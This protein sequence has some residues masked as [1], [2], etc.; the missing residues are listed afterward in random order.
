MLYQTCCRGVENEM[1][2]VSDLGDTQRCCARFLSSDVAQK[3]QAEIPAKKLQRA[4][5]IE[6]LISHIKNLLSEEG[7]A[8]C[9]PRVLQTVVRELHLAMGGEIHNLSCLP[10][11]IAQIAFK[12]GQDETMSETAVNGAK[13]EALAPAVEEKR[14]KLVVASMFFGQRY[15]Q[16]LA[17]VRDN[18]ERYCR[19]HDYLYALADWKLDGKDARTKARFLLRLFD[20]GALEVFWMDA[21]SLFVNHQTSL[22]GFQKLNKDLV[23][24]GDEN[25]AF[26]SGHLFMRNSAWSRQLLEGVVG[27]SFYADPKDAPNAARFDDW[28]EV[29]RVQ[30]PQGQFACTTDLRGDQCALILVLGGALEESPEHWPVIF[31]SFQR[32]AVTL[33]QASSAQAVLHG[34]A[35]ERVKIMPQR[36]MNA[37]LPMGLNRYMDL[38]AAVRPSDLLFHL[39]GVNDLDVLIPNLQLLARLIQ[40]DLFVPY[41][42]GYVRNGSLLFAVGSVAA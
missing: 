19:K 26:N 13:A 17:A 20:E 8:T 33:R 30:G 36:A 40:A 37:Y 1:A 27:A 10:F 35:K 24:S 31:S 28:S 3:I 34:D 7:I 5:A 14:P 39:V 23:F 32:P 16:E 15:Y 2:F 29:G 38:L 11:V 25:F 18:H 41:R 6:H 22:A 12:L 42:G 9:V 21:D 4:E